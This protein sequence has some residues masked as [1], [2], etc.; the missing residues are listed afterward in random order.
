MKREEGIEGVRQTLAQCLEIDLEEV[1]ADSRLV[2]DLG[3]DSLDFVDM[4]FLLE[5]RFGVELRGGE[6][7]ALTRLD[8]GSEDVMQDG[9]L[10]ESVLVKLRP[11]LPDLGE[12]EAVTPAEVFGMIRVENVWMA[13]ESRVGAG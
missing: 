5:E 10:T 6:L 8:P 4:I 3:A 7:D 11:W 9:K 12:A 1:A 13:I 2:E